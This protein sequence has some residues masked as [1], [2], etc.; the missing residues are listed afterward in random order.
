MRSGFT[1][2][3]LMKCKKGIEG[4]TKKSFHSLLRTTERITLNGF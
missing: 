3:I 1:L 4:Q 2:W